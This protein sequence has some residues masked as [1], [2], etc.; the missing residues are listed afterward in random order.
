MRSH[1]N[2][3]DVVVAIESSGSVGADVEYL[4]EFELIGVVHAQG[5]GH[6]DDEAAV[7]RAFL[8]VLVIE[9]IHDFLEAEG[10]DSFL[11]LLDASVGV[12]SVSHYARLVVEVDQVELVG[13]QSCVVLLEKLLGDILQIHLLELYYY[14]QK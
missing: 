11:D 7:D 4:R 3:E 2:G 14:S 10:F 1:N 9:L 8:H 5:A 13:H 12:A 6:E